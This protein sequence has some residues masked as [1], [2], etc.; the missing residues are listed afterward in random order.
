MRHAL[1]ITA[2]AGLPPP[3]PQLSAVITSLFFYL[4]LIVA[5]RAQ[6]AK[7][8]RYEGKAKKLR[9]GPRAGGEGEGEFS[10]A[11]TTSKVD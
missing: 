6:K 7:N 2:Y 11:T 10:N 9:G 3:P 4:P 8:E 1:F 5:Y